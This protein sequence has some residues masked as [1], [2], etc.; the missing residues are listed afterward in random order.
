VRVDLGLVDGED[1]RRRGDPPVLDDLDPDQPAVVGRLDP[2]DAL[3]RLAGQLRDLAQPQLGRLGGRE[4]AVA[5]AAASA[6]STAPARTRPGRRAFI[7]LV[8]VVLVVVVLVVVGPRARILGD[9]V[10]GAPA[11]RG[12]SFG[13]C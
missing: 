5:S 9:V 13:H 7:V 1:V 11:A 3:G 10:T 2:G 12:V 4:L 6:T 8:L